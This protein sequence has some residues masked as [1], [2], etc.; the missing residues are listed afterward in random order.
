MGE[1][2]RNEGTT[3]DGRAI[4][5]CTK[6]GRL[7]LAID[8]TEGNLRRYAFEIAVQ[9]AWMAPMRNVWDLHVYSE[10]EL[11]EEGATSGYEVTNVTYSKIGKSD[12]VVSQ[13]RHIAHGLP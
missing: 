9:N 13:A 11:V 10:G 8:G 6:P 12:E 1:V 5:D 2:F 7:G 4:V 3:A